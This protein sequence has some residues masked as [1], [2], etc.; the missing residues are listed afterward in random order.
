MTDEYDATV[1]FKLPS[2]LLRRVA[3][4]QAEL[5]HETGH[6]VFSRSHALRNLITLGLHVWNVG[7]VPL[8]KRQSRKKKAK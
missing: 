7:P 4:Y 6:D 2:A 1:S 5:N 8:K 3:K